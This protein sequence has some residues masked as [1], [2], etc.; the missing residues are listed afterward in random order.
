MNRFLRLISP[1]LIAIIVGYIFGLGMFNQYNET[2]TVYNGNVEKIYFFQ[3]GAYSSY[4]SMIENTKLIE[5]FVY[6]EEDDLYKVFI[7]ITSLDANKE[8]LLTYYD[9][10]N[11]EVI[12][13]E[14]KI[15]DEEFLTQLN[16]YD[17]TLL[18]IF[19]NDMINT[20]IKQTLN[21]YKESSEN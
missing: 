7:S 11:I 14:Y 4:E 18:I 2:L 20:V 6:L 5:N 21:A 9:N 3:Q 8:K 16:N 19:D 12:V 17:Q 1:L 10:L 15:N 13:K